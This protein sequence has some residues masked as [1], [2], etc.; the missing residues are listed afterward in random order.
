MERRANWRAANVEATEEG[1]V[2]MVPVEGDPDSDWDDAF[3]RVVEAHRHEVWGRR[4]GHIRHRPDQICVEQ[5]T[6]GS[7]KALQEFL[8]ACIGETEARV[9]QDEAERRDDA[10]A[11]AR[12]RTE[13]SHEYEPTLGSHLDEARRMTERFR[14]QMCGVPASGSGRPGFIFRSGFH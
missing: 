6:E 13:A 14:R 3:R 12:K 5:V 1:Y 7:E 11:L 2:L 10:E 4:W 8:D 9:R